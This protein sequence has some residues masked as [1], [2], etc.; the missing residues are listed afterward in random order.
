MQTNQL[1]E[2]PIWH[3]SLE[4]QKGFSR[5][6]IFVNKYAEICTFIKRPFIKLPFLGKLVYILADSQQLNNT[7]WLDL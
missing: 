6:V 3:Q 1:C 5:V 7:I 2:G 4:I